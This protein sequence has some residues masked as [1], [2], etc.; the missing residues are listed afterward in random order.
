M[1]YPCLLGRTLFEAGFEH[2]F[3]GANGLELN[4]FA[5]KNKPTA[6]QVE[7]LKLKNERSP[8]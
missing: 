5:F 2:V 1:G 6:Y 8:K 4:A 3:I 7:T